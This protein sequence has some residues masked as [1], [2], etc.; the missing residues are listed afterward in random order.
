MDS[1]QYQLKRLDYHQRQA[2]IVVLKRLN[3]SVKAE[4]SIPS[5]FWESFK[6]RLQ[7]MARKMG[8]AQNAVPNQ[9]VWRSVSTTV[10]TAGTPV[11]LADISIPDGFSLAIR[12]L[13]ANGAGLIY[14]ANSSANTGSAA[15][16][17]ILRAG[18]VII[19]NITNTNL[20]WIDASVNGAGIEFV[21]ET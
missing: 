20:V 4:F 5:A 9:T 17:F 8:S 14:V 12:G 2:R 6:A 13:T 21:I 1:L 3:A 10:T 7:T 15:N 18:D 11:N 16:R 19:L